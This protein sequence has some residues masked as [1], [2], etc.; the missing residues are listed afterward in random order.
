MADNLEI[1]SNCNEDVGIIVRIIAT[2]QLCTAVIQ[3]VVTILPSVILLYL[4]VNGLP[5]QSEGA[6]RYVVEANKMS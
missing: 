5:M 6:V 3:C 4:S 1:P 2:H